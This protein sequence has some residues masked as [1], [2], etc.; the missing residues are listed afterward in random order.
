M[1]LHISR[2][3]SDFRAAS[4]L[5]FPFVV[6]LA[7]IVDHKRVYM[8]ETVAT[9]GWVCPNCGRRFAKVNQGHKC[10]IWT[11]NDHLT[12][13][14][15]TS[16]QLFE[17]FIALVEACGPFEYSI[18]KGNIGLRG[19]KRIFAGVMPTDKGLSGYLDIAHAIDDPRFR[20]V[21]PYT[22]RLFVHH[23]SLTIADQLD[24]AFAGWIRRVVCCGT[25]GSPQIK[26]SYC[27]IVKIIFG[28]CHVLIV[29]RGR[30]RRC[31]NA[32]ASS[33]RATS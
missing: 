30:K 13:K 27:Q 25:G 9:G 26:S 2:L 10:E 11:L 5:Q 19:Q 32:S 12:G 24:Q 15:E 3:S 22:K 21:S 23:F 4:T 7:G 18:T 8:S 29:R 14:P 16:I 28:V 33:R 20:N 31:A 1:L 17:R 6:I